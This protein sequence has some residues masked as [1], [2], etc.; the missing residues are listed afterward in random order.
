L[1]N[2]SVVQCV[3]DNGDPDGLG[4][5]ILAERELSGPR[6]EAIFWQVDRFPTAI[7]AA[8]AARR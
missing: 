4:C 2:G 5:H 3:R 1:A 6:P 8:K 7:A